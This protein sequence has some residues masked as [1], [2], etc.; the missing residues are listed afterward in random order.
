MKKTAKRI[1]NAIVMCIVCIALCAFAA[2][3]GGKGG[4]DPDPVPP[5]KVSD[6]CSLE[7]AVG[8]SKNLTVADYIT[9]NGNAVTAQ[10]STA[11]ATA[12]VSEGLLT[13]TGA[14][15]GDATVTLSCEDISVEFDV[16]VF[17]EYTVTLDGEVTYVRA[18]ET[19]TLP[20]EP[21][22]TDPN[23]EFDYYEVGAEQKDPSDVLTVNS[24]IVV[25]TVTK[26]K[27]PVK[28]KDGDPVSAKVGRVQRLDVA[29]YITSYGATV[30]AESD[31]VA[32]VTATVEAGKIVFDPVAEG[33]AVVTV[34]CGQ[35][36]VTF[37][38]TVAPAPATYTVTVDGGDPE[39][40][41]DGDMYTL[42]EEIVP[43]DSD[44]EFKGWDVNGTS[45]QPGDQITV[46]CDLVI[47][48]VIERKAA[49][50]V[51]DGITVNLS[52]D[53]TTYM[54]LNV[55]DYITTYSRSV[56]AQSQS[57]GV[58]TAT[59]DENKLT[60]TAVAVGNTTVTL[61]CDEVNV[62]F[63]V[64]VSS[65]EDGAP[66]FVD[67]TISFDLFEKS[68]DTYNF[69]I[70][71]PV[72]SDFEYSYTVTP[73]TGVTVSGD[74]LTYT[75]SSAVSGLEL[76]VNVTAVD[77]TLGTKTTSFIVT[78]NVTDT[79]PTAIKSEITVSDTKDLHDGA[80]KINLAENI[81]NAAN[82]ASYKVNGSAVDG[83]EYEITGSY[84]DT[85]EAVTLTV[86]AV[87]SV[88]KSVTYTYTVNVIDTTAYRL[89]NGGFDDG[90]DGL[91]GWTLSNPDLGAVSNATHYWKE[92]V[93]YKADGAFFNAYTVLLNTKP[94]NETPEYDPTVTVS[95]NEGA[96]GTLTSSTFKVGGS[97]W[98]TYKLGGAKNKDAVYIEVVRV[99]DNKAVKLLNYDWNDIEMHGCQLV[100]Y[101]V[102]LIDYCGFAKGDD[103]FVRVTD[104]ATG[105]YGLFFLD[106]VVT[107]YTEE[108]GNEYS[109]ISDYRLYNGSFERGNLDGWTMTGDLGGVLH[110]NNEVSTKDWYQTNGETTEGDFLFTFLLPADNAEGCDNKENGKGTICS[111]TFILKKHGIISFRM[112]AAHHEKVYIN[113]RTADGQILATF[114]NNA[115]TAD[116][117]MVQY[118]YEF[119][120]EEEISCY[121]EIYDDATEVYG[122]IVMDDFRV[123]LETVPAGAV[124]GS[125]Q[126][127]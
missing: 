86:E 37:N 9:V 76:T 54:D 87:I 75:A 95:G 125:D 93:E 28:V 60:I 126:T 5:V 103:V 84:T 50:K 31:T 109:I 102:N 113:V 6:G 83:T 51:K 32:V 17:M 59:V 8:K 69:V 77:A 72:G 79:T 91:D 80:L 43:S 65:A 112:G 78:V 36:N 121:F 3:C 118:Y 111:S 64:N 114:R 97:G 14:S 96:T 99:S 124:L 1:A 122:C 52:V 4:S 117:V 63:T 19:Y 89:T 49:Q 18:G 41:D 88:E 90:E 12:T 42:P 26:R 73:D 7:V 105:D 13:V 94:E 107:Y 55:S 56:S 34:A 68:S 71:P 44:F 119:D 116:T 25:T 38:V 57:V 115:Y 66:V 120:N 123:N 127:K 30:T 35:V 23:M 21:T 92:K 48:S 47:T 82:V 108:P 62:T 2:A 15:V 70:T 67:G 81:N 22:V 39:T 46:T 74:S 110:K 98:M 11:C 40:V 16:S 100:A 53:G 33:T 106:S 10:S 85:A 20:A 61:S 45:K 101:K 104:N 24:N 58:A 27:A 29:D